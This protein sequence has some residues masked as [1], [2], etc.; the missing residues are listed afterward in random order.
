MQVQQMNR[1]QRR[2][3]RVLVQMGVDTGDPAVAG[4]LDR[5]LTAHVNVMTPA[6]RHVMPTV[7]AGAHEVDYAK[8]ASEIDS[9]PTCAN[10]PPCPC[11]AAPSA[12]ATSAPNAKTG[13]LWPSAVVNLS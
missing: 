8:L 12:F 1:V 3:W 10:A 13:R 11:P 4:R 5:V 7:L 6:L 2:L 9:V